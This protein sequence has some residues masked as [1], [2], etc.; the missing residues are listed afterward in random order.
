MGLELSPD[1]NLV[2]FCPN[3]SSNAS[4]GF[5]VGPYGGDYNVADMCSKRLPKRIQDGR[6]RYIMKFSRKLHTK[7]K[8]EAFVAHFRFLGLRRG[9]CRTNVIRSAAH[10]MS[11]ALSYRGDHRA[12]DNV[13]YVEDDVRRAKIAVAAYR[14]LDPRERVDIYERVQLCYPLDRDDVDLPANS[15]SKLI[16]K[17]PKVP[18]KIRRQPGMV[19]KLMGQPVI[20]DAIEGKTPSDEEPEA[21]PADHFSRRSSSELSL[22][23]RRGIVSLMRESDESILRGLSPLGWLRS[24]L[25]I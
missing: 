14:L 5:G 6:V 13:Q 19:V 3:G 16:D 18:P 22:E 11:A 20:D 17:M 4:N 8:N 25:G 23:E 10:A 24:R 1:K 12:G 15:T 7:K 2:N 9:E 21:A